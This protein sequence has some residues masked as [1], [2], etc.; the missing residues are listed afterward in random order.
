MM[1]FDFRSG[2]FVVLTLKSG[3]VLEGYVSENQQAGN[4]VVYLSGFEG[5]G[6]LHTVLKDEIA[7]VTER[8]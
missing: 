1:Q 8:R 2:R 4:P 5:R 7:A 3:A 6:D